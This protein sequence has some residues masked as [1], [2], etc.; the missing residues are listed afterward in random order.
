[1][2]KVILLLMAISCF[3][4]CEE[5]P[6]D[7]QTDL[8]ELQLLGHITTQTLTSR[9][10][11]NGFEQD[12]R[13]GVYITTSNTLDT[14]DFLSYNEAYKYEETTQMLS[15][16]NDKKIYWSSDVP[17]LS[18][19]AFYPY[20]ENFS[21]S[22]ASTQFS[23]AADQSKAE[24]FYNSDFLYACSISRKAQSTP[25]DLYFSHLLSK[26][27][28]E[29]VP[30]G[31]LTKEDFISTLD[32]ISIEGLDISGNI[33][34]K[35]WNYVTTTNE[36]DDIVVKPYTS[37]GLTYS[38]IVFP[39][40]NKT[41]TI[42]IS[43]GGAKYIYMSDVKL[44]GKHEYKYTL[45]IDSQQMALKASMILPWNDGGET[46]G[47]MGS[48]SLQ[49]MQ[50]LCNTI[51]GANDE[52]K[53]LVLEMHNSGQ[54][55]YLWCTDEG[56][57]VLEGFIRNISEG[58]M[59]PDYYY[60]YTPYNLYFFQ[61]Y[62]KEI[63]NCNYVI[64]QLRRC[65]E[66]TEEEYNKIF[67]EVRFMRAYY[68]W[69]LVRLYG[70]LPMPTEYKE[71]NDVVDMLG[72]MT[73]PTMT[74]CVDLIDSEINS[75]IDYMPESNVVGKPSTAA[76]LAI[77]SR[78]HLLAASPLYNGNTEYAG[79][80]N[81]NGENIISQNYD[82]YLWFKALSAASK[83]VTYCAEHGYDLLMPES[84]N[85]EDIVTNIRKITT[86]YGV[87]NPENLW[88]VEN[89]MQWYG[90][91]ALP[92]RWYGWNARYSLPLGFVNEFFMADGSE[93]PE[94][95]S[96]FTNKQFS[97]EAGNGTIAGTFHMF[98]G[99]EPRFYANIHFPNQRVNYRKPN[100]TDNAQD[101]EGYGIVDFWYSG[102][103]GY[104]FT[105]GDKN[106]TGFSV[107]K[108]IPLGY[109]S[110]KQNSEANRLMTCPFPVIRLGEVILNAAE[111][112]NEYYSGAS[113]QNGI[114]S[115]LNRIRERAGIPGYYLGKTYTQDELRQMIHHERMIELCYEGQRW[116]DVRR[117]FIAHGE[118]GVFNHVEYGLDMS[119]GTSQ[120]NDAGGST[121]T[122]PEFFTMVE[123]ANKHFDMK[124]YFMPLSAEDAAALPN[125]GQAPFY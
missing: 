3:V 49:K 95:E 121:C 76:A 48:V 86:T 61:R 119:K 69:M 16:P 84:D 99:R 94:L 36:A 57:Y 18:V 45:A 78:V 88:A 100:G 103:S 34:F 93:A 82:K 79:W 63:N 52:R 7:L 80:L 106:T 54:I 73:R 110:S 44:L 120:T 108:N 71:S 67:A 56:A 43:L 25:L 15:A 64:E 102:L 70:P 24:N 55:P 10:N 53:G 6:V 97:E 114:L 105:V 123:A 8:V 33:T 22:S 62:Y 74:K 26:I 14:S 41:M 11:D 89:S 28:I 46:T 65:P 58:N 85:F 107:R 38:A 4:S 98:V 32:E 31:N 77:L 112:L 60:G 109:W 21:L 92:A 96:W 101:A 27:T 47:T 59:S 117:W 51:Y 72:Q 1:M 17:Q 113:Y 118:N 116:F 111:A 104:R 90:M 68:Y 29:F 9:V 115:D 124:H 87:E 12:D 20:N 66:A 5:N 81:A 75:A 40:E 125:I 13:V 2:K 19:F 122:D 83:C 42:R 35:E 91:C 30:T 23:A 37:D 39:Q 50:E